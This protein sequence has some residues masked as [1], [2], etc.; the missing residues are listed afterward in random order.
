MHRDSRWLAAPY[1]EQTILTVLPCS[2]HAEMN[3]TIPAALADLPLLQT[4]DLTQNQLVSMA[5]GNLKATPRTCKG[6][7]CR[8][9]AE[10]EN[11]V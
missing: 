8:D 1:H 11:M 6:W 3:G 9:Q 4:L 10:K 5:W 7:V 2:L